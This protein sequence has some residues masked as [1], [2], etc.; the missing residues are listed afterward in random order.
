MPRS[1]ASRRPH[2]NLS[3]QHLQAGCCA[4]LWSIVAG[5]GNRPRNY[6]PI[7]VLLYEF[8]ALGWPPP[9]G[10]NVIAVR[11]SGYPCKSRATIPTLPPVPARAAIAQYGWK[12]P[13]ERTSAPA[14]GS[15]AINTPMPG[16]PC[17]LSRNPRTGAAMQAIAPPVQLATLDGSPRKLSGAPQKTKPDTA[18]R[19]TKSRASAIE[20]RIS[21]TLITTAPLSEPPVPAQH[22]V[23]GDQKGCLAGGPSRN[24]TDVHGFAVRCIATLPSGPSTDFRRKSVHRYKS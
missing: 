16:L 20:A 4:E 11:N 10:A 6:F 7:K 17:R 9:F 2:H 18:T 14:G 12:I 23:A 15:Q 19:S 3:A 1:R 22:A 21:K 5:L 24:R 13:E 8:I